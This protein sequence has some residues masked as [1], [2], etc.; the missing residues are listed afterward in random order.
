VVSI[1]CVYLNVSCCLCYVHSSVWITV[2]N[3]LLIS[4]RT[5]WTLC[6]PA[7]IPETARNPTTKGCCC[8]LLSSDILGHYLACT[9]FIKEDYSKQSKTEWVFVCKI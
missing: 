8:G 4:H 2:M 5:W 9:L 6:E 7:R 1:H 3:A